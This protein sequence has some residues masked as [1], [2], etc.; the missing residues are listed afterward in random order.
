MCGMEL[1]EEW[2][3][4]L[5]WLEMRASP[6]KGRSSWAQRAWDSEDFS[7]NDYFVGDLVDSSAQQRILLASALL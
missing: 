4:T 2:F 7:E 5:W 1:E 6:C 3:G